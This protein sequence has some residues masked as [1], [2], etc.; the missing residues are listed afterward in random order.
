M[1]VIKV[2]IIDDAVDKI[3]PFTAYCNLLLNY[4]YINGAVYVP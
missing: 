1:D 3:V 4:C 2:F